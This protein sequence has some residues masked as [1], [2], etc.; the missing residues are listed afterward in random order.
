MWLQAVFVDVSLDA[1]SAMWPM[2]ILGGEG[3]LPCC[4]SLV[5]PELGLVGGAYTSLHRLYS[6]DMFVFLTGPGLPFKAPSSGYSSAVMIK[7]EA[8]GRIPQP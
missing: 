2:P 1:I 6:A 4:S 7:E 8:S 5:T 3:P